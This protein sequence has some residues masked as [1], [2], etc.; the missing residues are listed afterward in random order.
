MDHDFKFFIREA[1]RK[2]Q[3]YKCFYCERGFGKTKLTHCTI[4]HVQ[5]LSRGGTEDWDN[6]VAAC[7][8]CNQLKGNMD[9][10]E[11]AEFCR[12]LTKSKLESLTN[13]ISKGKYLNIV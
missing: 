3:G 2:E 12:G 6:L 9:Y 8:R 13:K 1:L 5:P 4:D 7:Y 11:F 10:A